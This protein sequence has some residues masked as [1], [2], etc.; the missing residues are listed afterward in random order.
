MKLPAVELTNKLLIQLLHLKEEGRKSFNDTACFL[1]KLFPDIAFSRLR[2]MLVSAKAK[3]TQG[4]LQRPGT[5]DIRDVSG[6]QE[7]LSQTLNVENLGPF[8][9]GVCRKEILEGQH[10]SPYRSPCCGLL[11]DLLTF[12]RKEGKTYKDLCQWWLQLT[13]DSVTN[14][15]MTKA[16]ARFQG[17]NARLQP[18]AHRPKGSEIYKEFLS[19]LPFEASSVGSS[20]ADSMPTV[21]VMASTSGPAVN[22]NFQLKSQDTG[23]ALKLAEGAKQL[24]AL[25]R[26]EE[27]QS[28][29]ISE[30]KFKLTALTEVSQDAFSQL[31]TMKEEKE[32]LEKVVKQ[33]KSRGQDL[34][35]QVAEK[36]ATVV[37]LRQ[38]LAYFQKQG[39]QI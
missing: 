20:N 4:T 28:R 1:Q 36:D 25:R 17:K 11:K 5:S 3:Q 7:I 29:E 18:S 12:K 34:E 15:K 39:V 16:A 33:M 10:V 37:H 23:L 31:H 38:R 9:Q 35:G 14:T 30:M 2:Y 32:E 22:D 26:K 19:S 6:S 13:G 21:S 8:L 27:E 24:A